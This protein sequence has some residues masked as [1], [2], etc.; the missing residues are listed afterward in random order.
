MGKRKAINAAATAASNRIKPKTDATE[1]EYGP[2]MKMLIIAPPGIRDAIIPESVTTI[3][4]GAFGGC[5]RLTGIT[6]GGSVREVGDRA[7]S[8]CTSLTWVNITANLEEIGRGVFADCSAL[9]DV[10]IP[11]SVKRIGPGA[12]SGCSSLKK[13]IVPS[14]CKVDKTAF[15][16][17]C[18]VTTRRKEKRDR[19]AMA[20]QIA[21]ARSGDSVDAVG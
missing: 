15:P 11:D 20:R 16:P 13:C 4:I 18:V 5:S 19:K 9:A 1:I 6:I 12:F 14:K 17:G 2:R 3:R 10:L 21:A 7:F 8:G